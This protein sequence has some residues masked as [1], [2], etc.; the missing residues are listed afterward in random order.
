MSPHADGPLPL[1]VHRAFVV[2]LSADANL[3]AG[4]VTGRVEHV[5]SG[6]AA[7]FAS[8]DDLLAFMA[9]ELRERP[10]ASSETED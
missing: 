4:R 2:Q 3:D 7:T 10:A 1:S 5:V 8:L 9:W 6:H